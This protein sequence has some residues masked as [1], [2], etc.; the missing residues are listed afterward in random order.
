[1]TELIDSPARRFFVQQVNSQ[2]LIPDLR[3]KGHPRERA[4]KLGN[5]IVDFTYNYL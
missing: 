4:N 3:L 2:A 5:Y 1:M